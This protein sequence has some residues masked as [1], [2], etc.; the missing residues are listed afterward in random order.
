MFSNTGHAEQALTDAESGNIS[1]DTPRNRVIWAI[2]AFQGGWINTGGF[3]ATQRFVS[4]VTGFATQ[5]GVDIATSRW[6][7]AAG[8]SIVPIFFLIGA[9][10][11]AFYVDRRITAG[12]RPE[13]H[14]LFFM[15][16]MFLLAVSILGPINALGEFGVGMTSEHEIKANII[17]LSLLCLSSGIQNAGITTASNNFIRT[18]HLTGMTTDLGIGLV[19]MTSAITKSNKRIEFTKS[20][21]RVLLI[22]SFMIGSIAAAFIFVQFQFYGFIV[23]CLISFYLYR[24]TLK[25]WKSHA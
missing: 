8:M 6:L 16:F 24:M 5:F 9:M 14:I 1:I 18:T 10:T 20:Q 23:P 7:E 17:L 4:H 11:S 12:K 19:R 21:I 25:K 22:A 15:I 13:Y 2:L 3:L